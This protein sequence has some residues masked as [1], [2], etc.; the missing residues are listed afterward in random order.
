MFGRYLRN[1]LFYF[2]KCHKKLRFAIFSKVYC[3]SNHGVELAFLTNVLWLDL[4][5]SY[6]VG[7]VECKGTVAGIPSWNQRGPKS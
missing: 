7:A 5:F 3:L 1:L 2:V 6:I 4:F